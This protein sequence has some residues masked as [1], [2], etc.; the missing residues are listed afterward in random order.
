MVDNHSLF[1]NTKQ[2]SKIVLQKDNRLIDFKKC[3]STSCRLDMISMMKYKIDDYFF[4]AIPKN[5]N[6]GFIITWILNQIT[7]Y[8]Y[9]VKLVSGQ[10][11]DTPIHPLY[12]IPVLS[13]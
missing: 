1:N 4:V 9:K 7:M 3:Y 8:P 2:K 11:K 10:I 6:N 13:C 5:L 12:P